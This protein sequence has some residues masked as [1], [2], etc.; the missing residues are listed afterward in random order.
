MTK[1]LL[2]LTGGRG[3]PDMLVVKYLH[4]DIV[5]NIT[6]EKGLKDAQNFAKFALQQ[7]K[8]KVEVLATINPYD[9][10]EI[11][12]RCIEAFRSQPKA[13][14]TIHFTGS[15]KIVGIYAHDLAREHS[16][17]LWF[18]DTEGKQVVSLIKESQI[19][20]GELFRASVQEYMGAYGRAGEIAKSQTYRNRAE[21]WY[22]IAQTL[23]QMPE[24]TSIVLEAL[25]EAQRNRTPLT[26]NI[27][28]QAEPLLKQLIAWGVLSITG[29]TAN[30][31]HCTI[32]D[33]EKRDFLLGD[34]LEVYIWQEASKIGFADNCQWG[35]KIPVDQK[36]AATL[37]SNE[38]DLALT[39]QAR[40]LIAE[41]KTSRDPFDPRYL[42]KLYAI[43]NL[44]G[45]GYVRQVFV[46]NCPRPAQGQD[47]HF[48][49][50]SRQAEVRRISVITGEQL[51]DVGTLL[52]QEIGAA[53]PS[54]P[55]TFRSY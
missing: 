45:G 19:N 37:P 35:Y 2:L 8:C 49:N 15:P 36:I 47:D 23:V 33:N 24:A 5:Y 3:V 52:R 1:A 42:D 28:R 30:V 14:W 29:Q 34:W 12:D 39:Y 50:F 22:T 31:L 46:T 51:L 54:L 38:L 27:D 16:I 32:I 9:E 21:S 17:P 26:P 48:D 4:P 10:Q 18:L 11:K 40:L 41:C 20:H 53:G 43:A 55:P 25:R 13:E 7:F 6:T 44:V